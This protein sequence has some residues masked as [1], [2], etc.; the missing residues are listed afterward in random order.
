MTSVAVIGAGMAGIALARRL[1]DKARVTLLEKATGVSGRMA[2][3]RSSGFEF[4]HGAQY[5]TARGEAFR[6]F[7]QQHIDSRLLMDWQPKVVTL[8][9][10]GKTYKRIWYEPHWIASPGMNNLGKALSQ[11]LD[12][13]L[14][15]QVTA[16]HRCN[17]QWRLETLAGQHP[18]LFDWVVSTAPAP[19]SALLL[20]S[21]FQ[22]YDRLIDV[23]MSA[24]Y[25]LMLG[26]KSLDLPFGAAV[27]KQSTLGWI[28]NNSS[29]PGRS[30]APTL[31]VQSTAAWADNHL[32]YS[33]PDVEDSLKAELALLLPGLPQP[34][35]SDLQRW[36]YAST[37]I[38]A[39]QDYLLDERNR[40]AA[41]GDWC[42][43]NRV[44]EA[45]NSANALVAAMRKLV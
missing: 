44:E 18:E 35:H 19:Q 32:Q 29:K 17:N 8:E 11:G 25:T 2:V 34:V 38:P 41:C 31:V 24:C 10:G 27:V 14:E 12:I 28:A 30:E 1:G 4:D 3:R 43:N 13:R 5:F 42:R 45:F 9:P 33:L 6:Q 22:A 21:C 40:L 23:K 37:T 20:P 26:Y 39:N 36:R 16:L 15:Q 7:L